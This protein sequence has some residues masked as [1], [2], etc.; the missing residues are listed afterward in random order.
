MLGQVD[1]SALAA[2]RKEASAEEKQMHDSARNSILAS[3]GR[4]PYPDHCPTNELFFLLSSGS[5]GHADRAE[6]A[7]GR[8]GQGRTEGQ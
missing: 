3:T 2:E 1:R 7:E 5:D 4:S 8:E 6:A